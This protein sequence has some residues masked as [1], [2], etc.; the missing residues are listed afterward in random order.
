MELRCF[1]RCNPP[2]KRSVP[3]RLLFVKLATTVFLFGQVPFTSLSIRFYTCI[4]NLLPDG[5]Q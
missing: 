2:A 5:A 3:I 1:N 4:S